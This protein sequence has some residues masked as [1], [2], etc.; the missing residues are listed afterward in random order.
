M[1][2]F[3]S[4]ARVDRPYCVQI[5]DILDLHDVWYDHRIQAGQ[6]WWNEIT[7]QIDLREGFIYLLS[8]ESVASEYCRKEFQLAMR[9]GKHIF[10]VKIY[11]E[12]ELPNT[13]AH[14]QFADL[15]TGLTPKGVK[16]LLSAIYS[17]ELRSVRRQP[18]REAQRIQ[19]LPSRQQKVASNGVAT[20]VVESPP[21]TASRLITEVGDALEKGSY[22]HAVYLLK[23]AKRRGVSTRFINIEAVLQEA[24]ALLETQA[25]LREAEREYAPIVRLAKTERMRKEGCKAFQRFREQFPDY[26]PQNVGSLCSIE[27]MPMLEW[28]DIPAGEVT[29]EHDGRSLIYH[30]ESFRVG[31]YP[32]TNTQ[33]QA[34][35]DAPDGYG[36]PKWWE[37][38]PQ[39]KAWHQEHKKPMKPKFSWGDHPRANVCWYEAMAFCNW[40]SYQTGLPITLPTEQQW[41]RTAQGDTDR[42]YPWGNR[43][44]KSRC[45]SRES[46]LRMTTPVTR[47]DK[48]MSPY[49]VHDMAGNVWQ[50]CDSIEYNKSKR[51][52]NKAGKEVHVPRAVR[53]GSFISVAQRVKSTFHFYLNPL[54]RYATI[55]FRIA[56]TVE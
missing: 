40:L 4:Y 30:I 49:G 23:E 52:S 25:Y 39:A 56:T 29:I 37:F 44:Y 27:L 42:I 24:E 9:A 15:S 31:K 13:L 38:L 35:A 43:F 20:A 41:Q 7:K 50:W 32:V 12:V 1:R 2:L 19:R 16:Q 53:G 17:A 6:D 34:F 33:F 10:P 8:P 18:E 47:F 21:R 55:G 11:P 46:G 54:Y 14:L 36:N 48:G 51:T 5:N 22:D 26:D 3:I 28:C 45:N